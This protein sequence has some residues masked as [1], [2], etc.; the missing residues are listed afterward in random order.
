MCKGM[1]L[2][3]YMQ[4]S[5]RRKKLGYSDYYSTTKPL[6]CESTLTYC[7]LSSGVWEALGYGAYSSRRSLS[8][9]E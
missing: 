3:V 4:V 8:D 1:K 7:S 6:R 5:L 9:V 2:L